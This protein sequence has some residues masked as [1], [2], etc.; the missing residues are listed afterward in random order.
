MKDLNALKNTV[1]SKPSAPVYFQTGRYTARVCE[2]KYIERE[3]KDDLLMFKFYIED[4]YPE[5]Q[6]HKHSFVSWG[7]KC[8]EYNIIEISQALCDIAGKDIDLNA[9]VDTDTNTSCIKNN[10]CYVDVIETTWNGSPFYSVK[11]K[12]HENH[13][14]NAQ[15]SY[16]QDWKEIAKQNPW[17]GAPHNYN[18]DE[19]KPF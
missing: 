5:S 9:A 13:M 3:Q 19:P 18:D 14:P 11:F 6:N 10:L 16:N 17:N 7:K 4:A 2:V 12:T 15:P 8:N 1:I